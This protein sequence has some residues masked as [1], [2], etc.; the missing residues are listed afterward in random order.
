[1]GRDCANRAIVSALPSGSA[2]SSVTSEFGLS[3]SSV[4][5]RSEAHTSATPS[6]VA[7]SMNASVRYV[8]VG[9]RS[10]NRLTEVGTDPSCPRESV[11][12]SFAG[13]VVGVLAGGVVGRVQDLGDLGDLLLDQPLDSRLE[14]DV[15]SAAP[16]ASAAHLE[17]HP[18]VLHVDELD[19]SAMA[20]NRGIDHGVDQFLDAGLEF[21]AHVAT[22]QI[23]TLPEFP[24]RANWPS[25][26]SAQQNQGSVSRGG[27]LRLRAGAASARGVT[28]AAR[29]ASSRTRWK[30]TAASS[31]SSAARATAAEI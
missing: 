25:V 9:R 31:R 3:S 2:K 13:R 30:V 7:A 26:G 6:L 4:L 27:R 23:D 5:G 19:E 24:R 14:R 21:F 10:S 8:L 17:V 28:P 15:G 18:V 20:S 16:L 12:L 22:S 29:S 1:M 11:G